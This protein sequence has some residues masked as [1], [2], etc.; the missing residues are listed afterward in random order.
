MAYYEVVEVPSWY[1]PHCFDRWRI[2]CNNIP[3]IFFHTTLSSLLWFKQGFDMAVLSAQY[4]LQ[5]QDIDRQWVK[6]G[7]RQI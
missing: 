1:E 2:I 6:H 4:C 5:Y 7:C 3:P